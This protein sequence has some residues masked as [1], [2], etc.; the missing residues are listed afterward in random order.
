MSQADG[1]PRAR[2]EPNR[3]EAWTAECPSHDDVARK[4]RDGTA[5][6]LY[7]AAF[8]RNNAGGAALL[9]QALEAERV[10]L[11][12]KWRQLDN[13]IWAIRGNPSDGP[14]HVLDAKPREGNGE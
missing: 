3:R 11:D 6:M 4:L 5:D 1:P 14:P 10:K 7:L 8:A 9:L 13:D 12:R 2:P